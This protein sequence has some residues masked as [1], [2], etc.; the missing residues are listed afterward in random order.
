MDSLASV[1]A[2]VAA[3]ADIC[4]VDVNLLPDG[5]PVLAH[6]NVEA[7]G[8]L[9]RLADVFAFVRGST[10]RLN[11]DMKRFEA[12]GGVSAL[13]AASGLEGRVFLT[14]I[15]EEQ[16]AMLK[17]SGCPVPYYLNHDIPPDA[18]WGPRYL[19]DLAALAG[20]LGC[21]GVN[22]AYWNVNGRAVE[23]LHAAGLLVSVWTVDDALHMREMLE[24]G[25]DNITTNR[26]DLLRRLAADAP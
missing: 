7:D 8:G 16:A 19:P 21:V 26:P 22:T 1:A 11:L 17:A 12:V 15:G 23:A 9:V 10:V 25:V 14:G 6:N 2:G 18:E 3:G 5:T 13:A 20:E 24:A 4:E